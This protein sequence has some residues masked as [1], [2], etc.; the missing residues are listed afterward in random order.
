MRINVQFVRV[1]VIIHG[2]SI[3]DL[4]TRHRP[5]WKGTSERGSGPPKRHRQHRRRGPATIF[6]IDPLTAAHS[7]FPEE[8]ATDATA[9]L[10]GEPAATH[11]I[12][13]DCAYAIRIRFPEAEPLLIGRH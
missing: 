1:T 2:R 4:A 12:T 10:E 5:G 9:L 6:T 3:R 7:G 11:S 13:N 8:V